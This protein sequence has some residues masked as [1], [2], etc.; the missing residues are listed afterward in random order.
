MI[1]ITHPRVVEFYQ[2]NPHISVD[3]V[4]VYMVD[5]LEKMGQCEQ[6]PSM[7]KAMEQSMLT[8]QTKVD[9]MCEHVGRIQH[10]TQTHLS[11]KMIEIKDQYM[12][13]LKM[14]LTHNLSEKITP[15][16]KDQTEMFM[17]KTRLWLNEYLPKNNDALKMDM[18]AS[19]DQL[20]QSLMREAQDYNPQKLGDFIQQLDTKLQQSLT[21]TNTKLARHEC[22][23]ENGFKEIR[24]IAN[25]NQSNVSALLSKMENSSSKGKMSENL[26]LNILQS[27]YP[28]ACIDSVGTQKET[29]DVMFSR[30]DKCAILIE[31]KNYNTNVPQTEVQKFIRDCET[32]QCSGLFL[33]QTG[34]ICNKHNFEMDIHDGNVLLYIHNVHYDKEIIQV[35]IDIIDHFKS[36]L[37]K[38]NDK[39]DVNTIKKDVLD[40]I[41]K[42]Y[43]AYRLQKDNLQKMIKEMHNKLMKQVD[44]LKLPDLEN[45]LSMYYSFSSGKFTCPYCGFISEKKA[46]LSAHERGCKTKKEM[47]EGN[48]PI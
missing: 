4:N 30:R 18:K 21:E 19:M 31:N 7:L 46:G 12:E 45:Y 47:T 24:D 34:G 33:S 43:T 32:Q 44:E 13:Q 2:T 22:N 41:H 1:Q 11:L 14:T 28:S 16:F 9:H 37:D 5:L 36:N 48:H 15:L 35:G 27:V 29:G 26:L 40:N 38:I 39:V 42:E 6:S 20:Q 25:A 10:E 8:L 17:D 3:E 23:L